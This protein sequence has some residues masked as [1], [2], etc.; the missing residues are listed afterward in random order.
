[1]NRVPG[2]AVRALLLVSAVLLPS[3]W[4]P[5]LPPA[6]LVLLVVAAAALLHGP[7]TGV[8]VGLA[9]GWLVDLVPPGAEPLGA[10]A[11]SYAAAGALLGLARR[12]AAAS[13]LL[14]WVATAVASAAVLGVRG[15]VAAAGVGRAAPGELL[16]TWVLTML[17]AVVVLP[18][19]IEVER[20]L[21]ARRWA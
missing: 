5:G 8:L 3:A 18:V 16:R 19:L 14:P 20:R 15:V 12:W 13:P 9:G 7:S 11:L 17:V 6:D 10:T 1:M 4:P 21:T 2:L